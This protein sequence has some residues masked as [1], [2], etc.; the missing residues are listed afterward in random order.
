MS[1]YEQPTERLFLKIITRVVL[2]AVISLPILLLYLVK[3]NSIANVYVLMFVKSLFPLTVAGFLL[4]GLTDEVSL[5]NGLY[6]F[7]KEYK[8]VDT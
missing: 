1:R 6:D 4:F 3:V 7:V 8:L 5:R 2:S